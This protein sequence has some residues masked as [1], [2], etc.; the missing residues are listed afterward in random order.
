LQDG[1]YNDHEVFSKWSQPNVELGVG[2]YKLVTQL[3]GQLV[4]YIVA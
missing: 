4:I 3:L 2:S 1:S